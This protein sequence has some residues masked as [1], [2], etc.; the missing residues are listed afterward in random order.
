M[1]G[2]EIKSLLTTLGLGTRQL[3]AKLG[4]DAATVQA[5]T[6]EEQF[7]TKRHVDAM[8]ALQSERSGEEGEGGD[9]H[10]GGEPGGGT[11]EPLLETLA[12]PAVWMLLRKVLAYPKLRLEVEKAAAGYR[13]PAGSGAKRRET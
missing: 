3:A 1:T 4:V 9:R 11:G 2:D 13:D 10:E 7:P 8:R 5:W 12:D 6:R